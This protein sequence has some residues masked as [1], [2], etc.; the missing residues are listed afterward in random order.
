MIAVLLAALLGPPQ[1][2]PSPID[3]IGIDQKPGATIPLDLPFRDEEGKPLSLREAAGNK[4]F[5]LAPVYYRCPQLCNQVL[6]GL[7]TGLKDV[8]PSAGGPFH[9][10]AFSFDPTEDASLAAARK[11]GLLRTYGRAGADRGWRFLTGDKASIG[12]LC[13]GVGFRYTFNPDTGQYGHAAAIFVLTADG[14]IARALFGLDFPSRDLRLA[15]AEA[16]EGKT[17]SIVDPLLLYCYR[18][19]PATGRYGLSVL[20]LLRAGAVATAVALAA[21]IALLARRHRRLKLLPA[22]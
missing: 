13:D 2:R 20:R 21:A 22:K 5:I 15:I 7:L 4:P 9:V 10:V 19:D 8:G 14:R 17:G 12:R 3:G 11:A 1:A 6:L 16:A 18:Y